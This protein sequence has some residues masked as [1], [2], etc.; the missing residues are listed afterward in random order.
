MVRVALFSIKGLHIVRYEQ[1]KTDSFGFQGC[2][3]PMVISV[4]STDKNNWISDI[5]LRIIENA[6]YMAKFYWT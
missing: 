5:R 3:A 6:V 2:E 1:L 4:P